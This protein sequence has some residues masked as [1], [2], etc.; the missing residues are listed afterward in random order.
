LWSPI[1]ERFARQSNFNYD[2]LTLEIPK[3]PNQDAPLPPNFNTPYTLNGITYPALFPSV[4]V[5]RGQVDQYMIPWDKHDIGPRIGIAWNVLPK[6][7]I[8]AAYG[9]FYG[10]EEQQGGNPNRGESAP[11]NTSPQ[12]NRP[13]GVNGFDPNPFFANGNPTGGIAIGFPLTVFTTQ[14]VSSLQFRSVS[15]DFLNPMVQKWNFVVQQQLPS[16]MALEVGYQGNHQSHQLLQPDYNAAYNLGTTASINSNTLRPVPELGS[17]S[18]TSTFGF[19]NYEAMTAKLEKRFSHGLQFLSSYTWGH[20]LANSGTTLS[21]SSGFGYKDNRNISTSYASAAWDI[22][23]NFTTGFNYDLPFGRGKQYGGN[24][25]RALDAVVGG[26]T[27]N[28][29]LTFHTGQPF[30]VRSNGCQGVWASCFPDLVSGMDPNAA[31]SGGRNPSQW[32]TTSN[33]L[34]PASLTQGNLGLQ[35]NYGPSVHNVDFSIA[36]NFKFTENWRLQFRAEAFNLGNTPQFSLP[37]QNRQDP[38]FAVITST[39]AGSERHIQFALRLQ[40]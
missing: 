21:G 22:R 1:G 10:G 28:G 30:T 2:T 19:G 24:I 12:L 3:G 7:V 11:F 26:W 13:S 37:D 23:H 29:F 39:N 15:Q 34:P 6:T 38:N 8:R 9:I 25:N 33:F 35:T 5:S 14:P 32:F 31:P 16:Q 36:K 4:K 20:A 27:M 17:I 18:G 40:F